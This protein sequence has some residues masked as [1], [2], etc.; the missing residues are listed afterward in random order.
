MQKVEIHINGQVRDQSA[1]WFEGLVMSRS[2]PDE[3]VLAGIVSDQTD[4]YR[5]ISHLRGLGI[6]ISSINCED[7]TDQNPP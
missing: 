7:L 5:M 4:L 2:T 3:T 6:H 1:G